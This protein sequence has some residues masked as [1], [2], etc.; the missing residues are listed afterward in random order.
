MIWHAEWECLEEFTYAD[1]RRPR[2]RMNGFAFMAGSEM[3]VLRDCLNV[4]PAA[5]RQELVL[6]IALVTIMHHKERC[7]MVLRQRE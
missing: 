2:L 4:L 6:Q 1:I 5:K 7:D 3:D